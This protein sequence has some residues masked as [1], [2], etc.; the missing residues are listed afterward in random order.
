MAAASPPPSAGL[1]YPDAGATRH[2][3]SPAGYR[4]LHHRTRLG[5]GGEV[6]AAA[7][8]AVLGWRMH[9]AAG[10]RIDAPP[11]ARAETGATV[12]AS[13]GMG[14]VRLD[15]PCRVVWSETG[16]RLAGFGY[17][18]LPGHPVSGEEAFVV[19]RDAD[20]TVWFT[21]TAFSRPARWYVRLAGPLGPLLQ[22]AYARRCARTLRRLVAA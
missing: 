18:T 21:I 11:G 9:R 17:G 4:R 13:M 14:R 15:A 2:D 8:D 20:D 7:A 1:T 12:V 6:M 5:R 10:V 22:R 19:T 3:R 16:P